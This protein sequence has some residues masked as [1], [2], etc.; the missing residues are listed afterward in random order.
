M[1]TLAPSAIKHVEYVLLPLGP[2]NATDPQTEVAKSNPSNVHLQ[3]TALSPSQP[4]SP[5]DFSS[6]HTHH[7]EQPLAPL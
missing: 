4:I 3:T 6:D 1:W 5:S 2:Q 7:L